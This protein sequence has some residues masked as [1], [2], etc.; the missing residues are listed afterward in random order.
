[1]SEYRL[2]IDIPLGND[3]ETAIENANQLMQWTFS[4]VDS[5][6]RILRLTHNDVN[7]IN[8]RL[9]HDEDRQ[10]SNYL[11]KNENGHVSN[12]KIRIEI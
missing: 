7:Q 4:D 5:K 9:G 1:M 10:K 8:Y 6:E 2:H 12:K 3:E 11:Q